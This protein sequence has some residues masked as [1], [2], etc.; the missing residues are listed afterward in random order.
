MKQAYHREFISVQHAI[1]VKVTEL[2]HL[3]HTD[4]VVK[5]ES[6]EYNSVLV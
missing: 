4:I 1:S 3:K 2:P 6:L 5:P